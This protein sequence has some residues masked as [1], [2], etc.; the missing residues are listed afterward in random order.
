[1][2]KAICKSKKAMSLILTMTTVISV[3]SVCLSL[4]AGALTAKNLCENG[5]FET[6]DLTGYTYPYASIEEP[7]DPITVEKYT[8][9][10]VEYIKALTQ[11]RPE[12]GDYLIQA[13][14][15]FPQHHPQ[16]LFTCARAKKTV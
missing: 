12:T 14:H 11:Q 3:L 2:K 15:K 10:G 6:G 1:M 13:Q 5:D 4:Q 8:M 16:I 9:N 7:V